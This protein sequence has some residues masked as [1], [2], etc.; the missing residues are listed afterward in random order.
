MERERA[1]R[2]DDRVGLCASCVHARRVT[3]SRALYWMCRRSLDDPSYDKYPR[4]P[5]VAC[6]GFEERKDDTPR[7]S[8]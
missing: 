1:V 3:A 7:R 8:T 5:V 6:P 2:E 4:L